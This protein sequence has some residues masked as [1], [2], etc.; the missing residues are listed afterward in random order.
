[1]KTLKQPVLKTQRLILR[2]PRMNDWKDVVKGI[3]N[4]NISK[5]TVS[6]P[7]PYTKK[8]ALQ[9][10]KKYK[11]GEKEYKFFAKDPFAIP[12]GMLYEPNIIQ[13]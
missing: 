10:L 12:T 1:M 8:D 4:L 7:Y 3:N 11:V 9:Y 2:K 6:I 5:N 13:C